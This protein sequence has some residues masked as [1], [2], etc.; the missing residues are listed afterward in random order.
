MKLRKVEPRRVVQSGIFLL[1]L[2]LGFQFWLFIR[3]FEPGGV[4][5]GISHPDG[6]EGFLPIGG[7]TTLKYWLMTGIIHPFH[8]ASMFI[9]I[10][11]LGVSLVFKK[12][13]CGWICPVGFLS[14]LLYKPWKKKFK[15]NYQLPKWADYILR[16]IKYFLLIFFFII[17]GLLMSSDRAKE[18][19]DGDYWK[20]ADVKMLYFFTKISLTSLVVIGVLVL[21]SIPTRNFWCRFLCPYGALLGVI[22]LLS[23]FKIRRDESLC[24]KCNKCT[25]NCPAH[26]PVSTS[27]VINSPECTSCL[28]CKNGCPSG[29]LSYG[30]SPRPL[31]KTRLSALSL[32]LLVVGLFFSVIVA[33]KISGT[34]KSQLPR[35]ELVKLVPDTENLEHPRE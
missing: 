5:T 21:L 20:I 29:A 8:P 31:Q 23:P 7:F 34:W 25:R 6:V 27:R 24:H 18:F 19:L 30:L 28:T 10:S 12:S 16:H 22:G 26:L 3:Q 17:I 13:F 11:A 14:E 15:K 2:I 9:F 35:S 1:I 33:A 4:D 32:A